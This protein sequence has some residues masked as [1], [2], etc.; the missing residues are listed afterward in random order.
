MILQNAKLIK[1]NILV[2]VLNEDIISQKVKKQKYRKIKQ[3]TCG[4]VLK[5]T[6]LLLWSTYDREN[7]NLTFLLN[8]ACNFFLIHMRCRLERWVV[9]IKHLD[10]ILKSW[11]YFPCSAGKQKYSTDSV[12]S[13][14][15]SCL[16][17]TVELIIVFFAYSCKTEAWMILQWATLMIIDIVGS[18]RKMSYIKK[19]IYFC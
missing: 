14:N 10:S 17:L 13:N 3:S 11:R 1:L 9:M 7:K 5:L 16:G 18:Q 19:V 15:L 4:K 8:Q 12:I 6:C 2:E